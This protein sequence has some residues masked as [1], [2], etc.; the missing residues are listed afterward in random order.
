MLIV[1]LFVFFFPA[2]KHIIKPHEG[3]NLWLLVALDTV[4]D[5]LAA[6][7]SVVLSQFK[8]PVAEV[9]STVPAVVLGQLVGE[10]G[11]HGAEAELFNVNLEENVVHDMKYFYYVGWL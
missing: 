8:Q 9:A 7:K 3:S 11:S 5:K 1:F 4:R 10:A 2:Q 6:E